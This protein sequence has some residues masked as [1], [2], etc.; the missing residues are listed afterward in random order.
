MPVGQEAALHAVE[1]AGPVCQNSKRVEGGV[2]VGFPLSRFGAENNI[3]VGTGGIRCCGN[4]RS[5]G[6]SSSSPTI[7]RM[8]RASL[9][10]S[11]KYL[12]KRDLVKIMAKL[13]T[14]ALMPAS[15]P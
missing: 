6:F 1:N 4:G 12:R 11:W 15:A 2:R 3:A 5:P 9:K 8:D 10:L 14:Y 7:S 13:K